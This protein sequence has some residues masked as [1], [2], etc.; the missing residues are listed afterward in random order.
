[1]EMSKHSLRLC[2][3]GRGVV[4]SSVFYCSFAPYEAA[5]L[6]YFLTGRNYAGYKEY[7]KAQSLILYLTTSPPNLCFMH[8]ISGKL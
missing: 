3:S 1:M 7:Y 6:R 2:E 5:M 4:R 8:L